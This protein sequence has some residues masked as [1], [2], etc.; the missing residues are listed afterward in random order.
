METNR[1][2][3]SM[4]I[5][6]LIEREARKVA[7]KAEVKRAITND[8]KKM[9]FTCMDIKELFGCSYKTAQRFCKELPKIKNGNKTLYY[10][11][12]VLNKLEFR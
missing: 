7:T 9:F 6:Y 10:V 11:N 12:D 3:E 8:K 5:I 2:N 4:R 1:D